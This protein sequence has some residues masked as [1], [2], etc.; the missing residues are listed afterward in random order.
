MAERRYRDDEVAA[1]FRYATEQQKARDVAAPAGEGLTLAEIQQVGRDV[2]I[3]P[4]MVARAVA[5]LD[6]RE[7]VAVRKFLGFPIRVGRSLELGRVV[8]DAEWQRLVD[9]LDEIFNAQGV[10]QTG[11]A[12]RSWR[13]GNLHVTIESG[14]SGSR[15]RLRTYNEISHRLMRVGLALGGVA[16]V[17]TLIGAVSGHLDWG[18]ASLAYAALIAFGV[19][20]LR[21]P[22]WSRRRLAQMDEVAQKLLD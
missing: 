7:G 10:V 13:N 15:L 1:I 20:A 21:L 18:G 2:G 11:P 19:G 9:D 4:E 14:A 12:M 5:I 3:G 8:S 17:G 22:W 16:A 6:Q